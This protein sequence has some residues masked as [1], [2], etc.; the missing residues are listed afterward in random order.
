MIWE[1]FEP[2]LAS[3]T[4]GLRSRE[5]KPQAARVKSLPTKAVASDSERLFVKNMGRCTKREGIGGGLEAVVADLYMSSK[6]CVS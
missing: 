2:G 3:G 4:L 6:M 5:G 1:G